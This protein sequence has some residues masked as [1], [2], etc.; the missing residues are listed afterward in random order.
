MKKIT[1]TSYI[2]R[3]F[4]Y[5]GLS[6]RLVIH[7]LLFFAFLIASRSSS[8]FVAQTDA[9]SGHVIL[10]QSCRTLHTSH[11]CTSCRISS[12][13]PLSVFAGTDRSM[14]S[15]SSSSGSLSRYTL[16][17]KRI[18]LH[19]WSIPSASAKASLITLITLSRLPSSIM[20]C[21]R[22]RTWS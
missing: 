14:T 20:S 21:T 13:V 19:G 16:P 8:I 5:H 15:S 7:W 6:F 11:S 4:I 12:I 10:S 22:W 18:L 1:L 17:E 3:H 9:P 2:G